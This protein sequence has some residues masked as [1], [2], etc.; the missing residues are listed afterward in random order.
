MNDQTHLALSID[1][2]LFVEIMGSYRRGKADC[3]DIDI[4]ITRCPDDDGKT[5]AGGWRLCIYLGHRDMF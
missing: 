2:K 1:P 3:G 5:H 4:M